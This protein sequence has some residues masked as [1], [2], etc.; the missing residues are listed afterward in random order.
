VDQDLTFLWEAPEE[1][2]FEALGA[3]LLGEGIGFGVED[4]FRR[5]RF[6]E[7]WFKEHL[8]EIRQRI[9]GDPGVRSLLDD[10]VG[11]QMMDLA[12]VV[13][14]MAG[15]CGSHHDAATV[16]AVIVVRRGVDALCGSE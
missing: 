15:V 7:R 6:G 1:N 8:N 9:C 3:A 13:G 12:T 16:L 4:P 10:R 11:G 2:L 5:R 14:A